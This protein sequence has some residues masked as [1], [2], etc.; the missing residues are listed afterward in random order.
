[1]DRQPITNTPH[2]SIADLLAGY[3]QMAADQ[4]REA[5]AVEWCEGLIGDIQHDPD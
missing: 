4:I 2:L 5:E 1:V 3:Q